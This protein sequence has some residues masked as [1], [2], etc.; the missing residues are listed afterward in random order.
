M[1]ILL[2]FENNFIKKNN[3]FGGIE[4]L[5]HNFFERIKNKYK[6]ES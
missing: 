1:K 5:N 4:T 6:N 2:N 3:N